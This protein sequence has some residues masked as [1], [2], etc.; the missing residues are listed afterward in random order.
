MTQRTFFTKIFKPRTVVGLQVTGTTLTLVKVVN[1]LKGPEI[2][3][4]RSRTLAG[5]EDS[6]EQLRALFDRPV[7][8]YDMLVTSIPSCLG[9]FRRIPVPFQKRRKLDKIIKYQLE[10]YI[11]SP[12]EDVLVDYLPAGSDGN[13]VAVGLDKETLKGH[14][15]LLRS[16]GLEPDMVV[17]DEAAIFSL[18]EAAFRDHDMEQDPIA[19]IH[20]GEGFV[21]IQVAS[22]DAV[23]F[24]RILPGSGDIISAIGD[25]FNIY[26]LQEESRPPHRLFF[27]G[28]YPAEDEF[29]KKIE[30][31]TGIR[32]KA[33]VPW[34]KLKN[35]SQDFSRSNPAR[36][37]VALGAAL[38]PSTAPS[39]PFNFRK[40]EFSIESVVEL[41]RKMGTVLVLL[42]FL[43]GM[44][45][46][47][48]YQK[49]HMQ[50]QRYREVKKQARSVF[51]STFPGTARIVK[52]QE[53]VQ[54]RQKMAEE[55]ARLA[56]IKNVDQEDTVLQVLKAITKQ[57][58]QFPDLYL[59][60]FS[61]DGS[62]VEI[63]GNAMSFETVD[64]LK[65]AFQGS[66]MFTSVKLTGA[67]TTRQERKVKFQ[68]KLVK[69]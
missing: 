68:M 58:A 45:T 46:F 19:I 67:K 17:L 4:I 22:K 15:A 18:Y 14:L 64:K 38:S 49:E 66:N 44:L 8:K 33:W 35:R 47:H 24:V 31:V 26:A 55:R 57:M 13:A 60:N 52:G 32:V 48:L 59:E 21:G 2:A 37:A 5:Q 40:D 61:L 62:E 20:F 28:T 9:S 53:L 30:R 7:L 54:M 3:E 50:T 23:K 10:P 69:K 36:F 42:L 63:E 27:V 34:K 6:V 12:I 51:L 39:R 11:P 43:G 56:W 65:E 41:K 29:A 25:T 1:T 16:A